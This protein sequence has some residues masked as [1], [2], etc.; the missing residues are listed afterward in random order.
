[1]TQNGNSVFLSQPE[2]KIKYNLKGMM[3]RTMTLIYNPILHY[4]IK[5][6][7]KSVCRNSSWKTDENA[8]DYVHHIP[9]IYPWL[10]NLDI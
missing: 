6:S 10:L 9:F 1:M 2:E 3:L 4:D 7:N 5:K 8:C